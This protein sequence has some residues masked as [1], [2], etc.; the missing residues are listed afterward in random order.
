MTY[1]PGVPDK[2]TTRKVIELE[3]TRFHHISL[4]LQLILP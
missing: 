3:I 4:N 2:D 1:L